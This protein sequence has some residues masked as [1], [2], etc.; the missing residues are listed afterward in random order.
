M[1]AY[2][3]WAVLGVAACVYVVLVFPSLSG[4]MINWRESYVLMVGRDLCRGEG[5][6][7]LPRVD[8]VEEGPGITGMEFP[9][10][11]LGAARLA[12]GGP[13]QV[14]AARAL[15]VLFALLAVCAVALLA[16]R[17][18]EPEG[19]SF[20]LVAFAFSPL[21]VFYGRTIQPDIPALA[22]AL[23]SLALLDVSLP[24]ERPTRWWLY[25]LSAATMALGALVKLPV[26][27][28]GLPLLAMLWSRRGHA[29]L[30]DWRYWAYLSIST[31][32]PAVW[33][34]HARS[35]QERYGHHDFALGVGL[36]DLLRTWATPSFYRSIFVQQLF[37]TYA[38]PLVSV[39]A[40]GS[41]VLRWKTT[42]LWVRALAVSAVAVFFIAGSTAAW[43]F[44]YGLVAVP[45]LVF[46]SAVGVQELLR[47]LPGAR[48]RMA[49]L[50]V[51]ML[52]V[53][54][55]GPWRARKW[56]AAAAVHPPTEALRTALDARLP[57][58][59]RVL[60]VSDGD[61]KLLW[62]LDRKGPVEGGD[63][64][65]WLTRNWIGP[66]AVAVDVAAARERAGPARLALAS[67]GYHPLYQEETAEVW[68]P[69]AA[70]AHP[71]P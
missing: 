6:L 10:L 30:S 51:G 16:V 21:V 7:W 49:I 39:V 65:R 37:D 22:L 1:R 17:E 45:A 25:F 3:L 69:G 43:H 40:V 9:L 4:Q 29:G 70:A 46:A 5:T 61:P 66:S 23:V 67:A 56:F 41:L 34:I 32:P 44:S 28:Y 20:A 13:G 31:L 11:N 2:T 48:S 50:A 55:Y 12:C 58:D 15:T 68:L 63:L 36:P 19:A 59:E 38:F 64:S 47:R 35:L 18:F 53:T 62:Y 57:A 60:V 54:V 27:V 42:Q 26:I 14:V 33:Y 71:A 8:T 24:K 52:L